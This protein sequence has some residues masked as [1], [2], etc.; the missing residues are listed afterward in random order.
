MNT[1][2]HQVFNSIQF[3]SIQ[4]KSLLTNVIQHIGIHIFN[5]DNYTYHK[6]MNSCAPERQEV[7]G[8]LVAPY[9]SLV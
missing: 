8:P 3:N 7:P 6:F 1:T 9:V 2:K 5:I 4:F